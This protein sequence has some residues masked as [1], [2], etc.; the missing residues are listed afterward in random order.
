MLTNLHCRNI[1]MVFDIVSMVLWYSRYFFITIENFGSYHCR[2]KQGRESD[3][4]WEIFLLQKDSERERVEGDQEREIYLGLIKKERDVFHGF[5]LEKKTNQN[6][7]KEKREYGFPFCWVV[8]ILLL[9]SVL[10]KAKK[11]KTV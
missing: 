6:I 7:L 9:C 10:M 3:K 5:D 8:S 11:T 1:S 2:D 4:F